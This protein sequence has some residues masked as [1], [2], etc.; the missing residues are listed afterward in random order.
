M[1][2]A[3]YPKFLEALL[4]KEHD[5]N[6]DTIKAVLVNT[7]T[8]YT[9]GAAHDEL[10]DVTT[11]SGVTAQTITTPTITDGTFNGDDVTFS[12]VAIDGSKDVEAVVIYN[13]STVGDKL[14]AY[15]DN[16]TAITPNGGDITVTFG[17]NIFSL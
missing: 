8:D 16:F 7:T 12:A 2:D 13:D 10:V 5:L 15:Y 9:Y 6:T 3:L 1:A 17:A 4:N 11:Y 14:I